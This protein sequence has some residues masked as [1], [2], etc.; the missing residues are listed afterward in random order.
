MRPTG[1]TILNPIEVALLMS[2]L[3]HITRTL[4]YHV[5]VFAAALLLSACAQSDQRTRDPF[6]PTTLP[7]FELREL[8]EV[9]R[10]SEPLLNEVTAAA[11]LDSPEIAVASNEGEIL[12]F[13]IEGE[14]LRRLGRSGEGP[15][16]FRF[17]Q[18]IVGLDDNRVL[19]W[20]PALD[21][22]TV[23]ERDGR[24]DFTCTPLRALSRQAGVSFV[25]AFPDGRFVLEERPLPPTE[26]NNTARMVSDTIPYLM[27]DRSGALVR[28]IG[29]FVRPPRY[30]DARTGYQQY[31]FDSSVR[32]AIVAGELYV[33]E[34]NLIV[35]QRFDSTGTLLTTLALEREPRPVTEL[36]IEAGWRAWAERIVVQQ[37]QMFAQAAAS[38][39]ERTAAEMQRG[40]DEAV[41]RA[42][43]NI[44]PA[45]FLPAYKSMLVGGDLALWLEDYLHPTEDNTRW[46]LMGS[47]FQPTGWIELPPNERLLAAGPSELIVLRKDE[48]DVESVVVYRG[49]WSR[50]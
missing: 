44:E 34:N 39:G 5:L 26:E 20:D 46:F 40:A 1:M 37:G 43:E 9:G 12:V 32:S 30:Y 21:R 4:C 35:L 7:Q 19:A 13:G 6:E 49:E 28:T 27:F 18:D 42:K 29:E 31:L 8:F 24:L 23:F 2:D 11:F 36:D 41:A 33:G 14:F 10:N 25:G 15:G 50:Q 16:E 38:L 22:V 47:D 17:I 45:E 48:L 3:T